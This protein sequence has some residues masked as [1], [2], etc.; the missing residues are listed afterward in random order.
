MSRL[1][2][3]GFVRKSVTGLG[4]LA[5]GTAVR[6]SAA[7]ESPAERVVLALI[8][9]GGRG[10]GL[11]EQVAA[12]KDCHVKH[13]CDLEQKRGEGAAREVE[14][15]QGS[16]PKIVKE[17]RT[18]FDDKDVHGVIVATPEQWHGLATVRA[19]QAGKDVYVEKCIC[20]KVEEGRKMVQAAQ[21]Y[22]RIVQAG[23]Q[24]RATAYAASAR[25]YIEEGNLGEV[26]LVKAFFMQSGVYGGYPMRKVPDSDP[27]EGLDWD[28]WLGPAPE[29]PYNAQVHRQWYGYWDYS[30]GN[31]SDAIHVLDL[32]RL[33]VG[34]PPHP[35]AVNCYGGRW[36]YDDGGQMPDCQIVT[37]EFDKLA[38]TLETTGYTR[39]YMKKTPGSIRSGKKFPYWPQNST[40]IEI[41]GTKQL[42]VLGRHGGG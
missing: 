29:R 25:K 31:N 27:P 19:C 33:A 42:L 17:M 7:A 37:Y 6:K 34:D 22:K 20:R 16:A 1:T 8:G 24:S 21:K 11:I 3:R 9:A 12:R 10:R 30:G 35:K 18:V 4:V 39:G 41:Y 13:I 15:V 23:T 32:A 14:Q 2:R 26:F 5:A 38:M 28:A 36:Q 40:R